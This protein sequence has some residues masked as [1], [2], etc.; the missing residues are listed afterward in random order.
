[1][2]DIIKKHTGIETPKETDQALDQLAERLSKMDQAEGVLGEAMLDKE[3]DN[4]AG[5]A[6]LPVT[7][8]ENEGWTWCGVCNTYFPYSILQYPATPP[9][10]CS[11]KCADAAATGSGALTGGQP[12]AGTPKKQLTMSQRIALAKGGK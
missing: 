2:N 5:G 11:Q 9:Q 12:P 10:F 4:V 8:P 3:L 6:I 7:N 1:M